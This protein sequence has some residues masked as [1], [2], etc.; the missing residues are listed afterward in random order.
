[1]SIQ[2]PTNLSSRIIFK[3]ALH[4]NKQQTSINVLA[5]YEKN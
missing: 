5:I 4:V 2:K 1:M 3:V